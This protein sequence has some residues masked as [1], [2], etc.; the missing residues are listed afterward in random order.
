MRRGE[1]HAL[2]GPNGAGKSTLVNLA[3][4]LLRP[5]SGR[6]YLDGADVTRH[7]ADARA[8]KGLA[9]SFQITELY[10]DLTVLGNVALASQARAGSMT[11]LWLRLHRDDGLLK[12]GKQILVEV[13]LLERAASVVAT[14]SHGEK[15]Q[16]EFAMC[17]CCWTS[18]WRG[19]DPRRGRRSWPC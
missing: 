1:I 3:A 18:R 13:D 4:E 19:W 9:R 6:V 2:L 11:R 12:A 10:P 17:L 7:A 16:L 5:D 8:R 15:R 14:L